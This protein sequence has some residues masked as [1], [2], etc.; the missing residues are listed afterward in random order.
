MAHSKVPDSD[1]TEA[2]DKLPTLVKH[3][4][5]WG[6]VVG[7]PLSFAVICI[8]MLKLQDDVWI[9]SAVCVLSLMM[10]R[11][12]AKFG[13]WAVSDSDCRRIRW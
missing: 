6:L 12:A 5:L 11:C 9:V 8:A 10:N 3:I 1:N 13:A 7:M 4:I 2:L